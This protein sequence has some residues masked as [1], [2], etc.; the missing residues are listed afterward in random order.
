VTPDALIL[1]GF[2]HFAPITSNISYRKMKFL[3]QKLRKLN[4]TFSVQLCMC[5]H[6][7]MYVC[8][9]VC[10]YV[11]YVCMHVCIYVI[12]LY[13]YVRIYVMYVCTYVC[14]CMYVFF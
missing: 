11:M 5:V 1:V 3:T 6:V 10:I 14:L 12:Y 8:K 4:I 2:V 13:M 7:Y 9:Y